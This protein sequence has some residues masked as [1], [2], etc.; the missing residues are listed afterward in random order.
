M[1]CMIRRINRFIA[2]TSFS[3]LVSIVTTARYGA[4]SYSDF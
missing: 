3:G 1:Y 4:S 2:N